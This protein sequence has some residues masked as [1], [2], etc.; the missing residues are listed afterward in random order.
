MRG[1]SSRSV[2]I[3]QHQTAVTTLLEVES[4][5]TEL[6]VKPLEIYSTLCYNVWYMNDRFKKRL[7]SFGWRLGALLLVEG[8]AFL[9]V[10][11]I[12]SELAIPAGIVTILTLIGGEVTKALNNRKL[13]K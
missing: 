13:G 2:D 12:A 5:S 11:E 10:P 7:E 4:V 9:T 1:F 6:G 8:V 3:H